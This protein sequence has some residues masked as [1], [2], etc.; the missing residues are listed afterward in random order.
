MNTKFEFLGSPIKDIDHLAEILDL[1]INDILFAAQLDDADRYTSRSIAKPDGRERIVYNPKPI[2]RKIQRR[3]KNR[4]FTQ[5]SWPD[6]VFGSIPADEKSHDFI[7]CAQQHCLAQSVLKLDI[8]D[9]FDNITM[10][11]VQDIFED[12]FHYPEDVS[13]ILAQLCCVDLK[14]PQGGITSSYLASIALFSL[15]E[16]LFLRLKSKKLTYTR[17]VDDITISSKN[18]DFNYESIINIVENL[19]NSINL[20]LNKKKIEVN[21]FSSTPLKVHNIRID[22]KEPKY[23][24]SEVK[25]IRAAIHRLSELAKK[26]NHRT[27]YFY[28]IDFNRCQ[29][30]VSKLRRVNHPS[31]LKLQ[32]R[33]N[34]IAPIPNNADV[35]YIKDSIIELIKYFPQQKGEGSYVYNKRFFKT[36]SRIGFLKSHPKKI[37]DNLAVQLNTE[38]QLYRM[39]EK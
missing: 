2:F 35:K 32:N 30:L 27:H 28:R 13:E 6:F 16:K 8:E 21:R 10:R 12:F 3:I 19:L 24:K 18:R 34:K 29:G 7:E 25:N 14:V 11:L 9:F 26:P 1:D 23:D 37:Y 20:P 17:Y 36:Q 33:L 4:L 5:I 39:R 38:L 22:F 15:E 31:Y